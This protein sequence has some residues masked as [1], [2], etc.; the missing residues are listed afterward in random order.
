METMGNNVRKIG[1]FTKEVIKLLDLNEIV[2]NT[3]IYIGEQNE[4]HIKQKHPAEHEMYFRDIKRILASPSYIGK[5][6]KDNS[7]VYVKLYKVHGDYIRVGVKISASGRF[8]ARTLHLLSTYNAERYI[9]K[10][11]LIKCK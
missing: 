11:T 7:I 1:V 8:Y 5:N 2:E 3:P 10:G 9:E 6:P 4:L